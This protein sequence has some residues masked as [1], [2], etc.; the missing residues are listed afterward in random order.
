MNKILKYILPVAFI[1]MA[2][3]CSNEDPKKPGYEYM[4]DM[5]RSPSYETYSSNP[6]FADSMTA[7]QPVN[8]TI[9]RG[10]AIYSDMDRMPYTYPNTPEG[11]EQAGLE[12]KNPLQK[13]EANMAEGL[14]LYQN[15]CI[16]CHGEKGLGDGPVVLKNG[17]KPPAYNSDLLKNL[18]EGKMFHT[19]EYGKNMMGSHASQL[20]ASQRWKIIMYVQT[21]QM[22][23]GT[24]AAPAD[25]V[26]NA[27][28]AK[29]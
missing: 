21:L 27:A 19:T 6:N 11:Y 2:S 28:P 15:Y 4:P 8:G 3:S 24:A 18:P 7:R 13:T 9:A 12:L 25:S 29:M 20:T 17:P 14:R 23:G 16:I 1:A 5:Y 26:K 10:D 22:P